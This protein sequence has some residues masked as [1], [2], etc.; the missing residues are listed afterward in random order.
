MQSKHYLEHVER[1]LHQ[2]LHTNNLAHKQ[3]VGNRLLLVDLEKAR[4]MVKTYM[5]TPMDVFNPPV[6]DMDSMYGKKKCRRSK[7]GYIRNEKGQFCSPVKS[8][9]KKHRKSATK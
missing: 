9:G 5:D 8:R 4:H 7:G 2:L 3:E 6:L 1:L